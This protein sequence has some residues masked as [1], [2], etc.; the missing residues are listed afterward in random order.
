MWGDMKRMYNILSTN[1]DNL[2]IL[3]MFDS[4]VPEW[5]YIDVEHKIMY[6]MYPTHWISRCGPSCPPPSCSPSVKFIWTIFLLKS[7]NNSAEFWLFWHNNNFYYGLPN[8]L[9]N[10]YFPGGCL[11]AVGEQNGTLVNSWMAVKLTLEPDYFDEAGNRQQPRAGAG[12][13]SGEAEG[14][15]LRFVLVCSL[16]DL[17]HLEMMTSVTPS[18]ASCIRGWT[19]THL[20]PNNGR[21]LFDII[22]FDLVI[23]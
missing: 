10:F 6:W 19:W 22:P 9:A 12:A 16:T 23:I 8:Y 11:L 13:V 1:V 7:S 14:R 20:Q 18:S 5:H 4:N 15:W 2:L 21:S 3:I 17:C